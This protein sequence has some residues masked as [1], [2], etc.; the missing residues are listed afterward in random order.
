[1]QLDDLDPISP[2]IPLYDDGESD[3]EASI[4]P[5]ETAP[6]IDNLAEVLDEKSRRDLVEEY[7]DLIEADRRDREE[8]DKIALRGQKM[9][10]LTVIDEDK[11]TKGAKDEGR[12]WT[13]TATHPLLAEA[14]VRFQ[15]QSSAELFPP[16]GPA[17][18]HVIPPSST[19]QMDAQ[20]DRVAGLINWITTDLLKGYGDQ[21]DRLL[22]LLA[23]DGVAYTKMTHD[24]R[25]YFQRRVVRSENV[26]LPWHAE[27]FYTADRVTER[28]WWHP[29]RIKRMQA[30]GTIRK[31]VV[32]GDGSA[33]R[34]PAMEQADKSVGQDA[35]SA[36]TPGDQPI[37]VYE[38]YVTE[39]FEGAPDLPQDEAPY[40]L[41]IA[42]DDRELLAVRRNWIPS[43]G[44]LLRPWDLL[45]PYTFIPGDHSGPYAYGLVHLIGA[46]S[47]AA[48]QLLRSVLDIAAFSAKPAGFLLQVLL[49]NPRFDSSPLQPGELRG[50]PGTIEDLQRALH[51]L[52]V[53]DLNAVLT[54]LQFVIGAGQRFASTA[55]L[56]VGAGDNRA[57]VGTTLAMLEK[58]SEIYTSIHRRLHRAQRA[59]LSTAAALIGEHTPPGEPYPYPVEAIDGVMPTVR[60]DFDQTVDVAPVSDPHVSSATHRMAIG[61]AMVDLAKEFPQD[62]DPRK[63]CENMLKAMRIADPEQYLRRIKDAERADFVSE[64]MMMLF[65]QPVRAVI[66]QDHTAHLTGHQAWFA[67]LDPEAQ[68]PLMPVFMAHMGEHMAFRYRAEMEAGISQL[69]GALPGTI[70]PASPQPTDPDDDDEGEDQRPPLPP[71]VERGIDAIAA[72]VAQMMMAQQQQA[73]AAGPGGPEDPELALKREQMHLQ[74]KQADDK[75]QTDAAIAAGEL[76]HKGR[77]EQARIDLERAKLAHSSANA[78]AD[79]MQAAQQKQPPQ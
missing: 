67:S 79:R 54:T 50:V 38:C 53:G 72:Q 56:Q 28:L 29:K 62:V 13:S 16:E 7:L 48:T 59:E 23:R 70:L 1:M 41:T 21:T 9:M 37:E 25:T 18:G 58:G 14:I 6:Y 68:K 31:D 24:P 52:P 4:V 43:S 49:N 20:A 61:Q 33:K 11:P 71:E 63:A 2:V 47:E 36:G 57:P 69:T 15:A 66:D 8:W 39:R 74:A 73:A 27:T 3:I 35:G 76:Q 19:P 44:R 5:D 22:F 12:W 45:T 55:D 40:V 30:D 51:M 46:L 34:T 42:R 17:K 64:N 10:G 78:N 77:V 26:F 60:E 65:Q 75:L 32:L